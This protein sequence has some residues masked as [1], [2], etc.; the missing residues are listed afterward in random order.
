MKRRKSLLFIGA[1]VVCS[2]PLWS[3]A[4]FS[5]FVD[6]LRQSNIPID[7]ILTQTWISRYELTRLLN[8]VECKDCINPDNTYLKTY[9]AKYWER[10]TKQPSMRF[11]DI[12]YEDAMFKNKDYYYCVAYVGSNWYMKGYPDT[13]PICKGEFCGTRNV[14]N[15]EFLQVVMN[16]ISKYIYSVYSLNWIEAKAWIKKLDTNSYQY[17]TFS[18]TD[19]A[20]INEKAKICKNQACTLENT[21]QFNIY[22]KYCMFNLKSCGMV[23]FDKIKE[24]YWPVTELNVLSKQQIVSIDEAATYN[25]NEMIAG[26]LLIKIFSNMSSLIGCSFNNDYDCDGLT[27]SEDSCPNTYN[28]NQTDTDK[29]G[30]GDV[31]DDD[32][33]GDWSKNPIG[34]VDDNWRIVVWLWDKAMDNCLFVVNKDQKKT[35]Q[36]ASIGDACNTEENISLGI[37]I[38]STNWG[39][40][41][42]VEFWAVYGSSFSEYSWDFGDGSF[43]K[44]EKVSHGYTKAGLYPVRLLAKTAW[45]KQSLA[46]TTI[47]V[48]SLS[49]DEKA[50]QPILKNV[51]IEKN[52]SVDLNLSAI[53]KFDSFEWS[54]SDN[55]TAQT[56]TASIKKLFRTEWSIQVSVKALSNNKISSVSSFTLGIWNAK[57]AVLK[58][59]VLNPDK[60][61]SV[62]FSTTVA[63]FLPRDVRSVERDFGDGNTIQTQEL[64]I[65]HIYKISWQKAVIQTISLADGS[66][67]KTILTLYVVRPYMFNS[68]SLQFLPNMKGTTAKALSFETAI[69]GSFGTPIFFKNNY[70]DSQSQ[71]FSTKNIRSP[72]SSQHSYINAD[73]YYPQTTLLLD[74]CT[75]L[76]AQATIDIQW[77]DICLEAKLNGTL[78]KLWCDMDKDGIPDMCDTDIDGDGKP[79]L[80]GIITDPSQCNYTAQIGS[81]G[82][83]RLT[84][85]DWINYDTL[86]KHFQWVCSLDNDPFESNDQSDNNN[87][88][89]GDSLDASIAG[90]SLGWNSATLDSFLDSDNDGI[91]DSQDICPLLAESYNGIQDTDGCPEIG[92]EINCENS[93]LS[94]VDGNQYSCGNGIVEPGENCSNCPADVWVCSPNCNNGK[95]DPGE[96]CQTCPADVWSCTSK[97]GDWVR[98]EWE[99]C[100]NCPADAGSCNPNCGNGKVDQGEDCITCPADVWSCSPNCGNKKIDSGE[101]CLNCPTDVGIC[102]PNCGNGKIDHTED[103]I[104][105]PAD[106]GV[107]SLNCKNGKIDSDETCLNCP[108]D[109]WACIS[110][111][112]GNGKVDPGE[113]CLNCP[114][115]VWSCGPNCKNGKVDPSENCQNCPTDIWICIVPNCGNGKVDQG[116]DCQN[117]PTDVWICIVP[118]PN[119]GNGVQ[120]VGETCLNCPTDAKYCDPNCANGKVD[121]NET[122]QNCPV[123]VQA[124]FSQCGNGIVEQALGEQ[125]DNGLTNNWRDGKCGLHCTLANS[126][127]NGVQ[128]V[129]ED[130]FSCPQDSKWCLVIVT[131]ECLQCPCPF[132]DF[133]AWLTNG[134]KLKA[135]LWDKQKKYPWAYSPEFEIGY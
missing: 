129:W 51:R 12:P 62:S 121:P 60:W 64:S 82:I 102:S 115:D 126:C 112:C 61:N 11:G 131:K 79:N 87:N 18:S 88:N 10:F 40:P 114:A 106:V 133:S 118:D 74:A 116:E 52:T 9:T 91:P 107:C 34:I 85:D 63:W 119:C 69:R 16:M 39:I 70:G 50:L 90:A 15:A 55:T 93:R 105:C 59:S 46:K 32:I 17:K 43:A 37:Q 1:A 111:N 36:S 109:V 30:I 48:W 113:N 58:S 95:I 57:W 25:V 94:I 35:S 65:N 132:A 103:C 3:K 120:E 73:V 108:A 80:L 123:D 8:A 6:Q 47:V 53:G 89:I 23:P 31:C 128:D 33:D 86:K 7:K 83:G 19:I 14:T 56:K 78:N 44:W 76:S 28:P 49:S 92:I 99:T 45:G 72:I 21:N 29:D 122:C 13:S 2:L 104:T 124:C 98:Q 27:N 20:T 134:D 54:F 117:C 26:K 125:C 97:C 42:T 41:Q 68:Y 22:L 67:L 81:S 66:K 24:G 100:L 96:T 38:I 4:D 71:I 77:G 84:K 75:N 110:P 130:C 127:G 135:V 5:G 101:T